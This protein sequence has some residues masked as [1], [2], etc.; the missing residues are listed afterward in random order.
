MRIIM[1]NLTG[2]KKFAKIYVPPTEARG[3]A[4]IV[5][6]TK[7][8][9]NA[10]IEVPANTIFST[11]QGIS[12]KTTEPFTISES[13]AFKPIGVVST[14]VGLST[15]IPANQVWTTALAGVTVTNPADFSQG[16]DADPGVPS[17]DQLVDWIPPSDD[18]LQNNLDLAKKN[19]LTKLGNPKELPDDPAIDRSVYL[20]AQFYTQNTNTQEIKTGFQGDGI[21]KEK[22]E[23]YRGRI[24]SAINVEVNNLLRPFIDVGK[25]MG[26]V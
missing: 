10:V 5:V 11:D 20:F 16:Q 19:V 6:L 17:G 21:S 25:F 23:Y 2:F 24:F 26:V 1:P 18:V 3:S 7:T 13:E 14:G 4:G 8:S 15:N 9:L 22:T 12:F